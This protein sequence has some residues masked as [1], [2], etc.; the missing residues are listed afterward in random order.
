MNKLHVSVSSY[1]YGGQ[2]V[3]KISVNKPLPCIM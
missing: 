2:T 1:Y 3:S